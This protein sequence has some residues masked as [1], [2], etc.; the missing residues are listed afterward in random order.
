MHQDR[1]ATDHAPASAARMVDLLAAIRGPEDLSPERLQALSGL[2]V[3]S[4]PDDP[5]RYGAG[6][7]MGA[8]ALMRTIQSDRNVRFLFRLSR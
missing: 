2:P 8:A 6:L 5:R 4:A 7:A 3:T 1:S